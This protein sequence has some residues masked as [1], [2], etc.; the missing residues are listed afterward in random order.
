MAIKAEQFYQK[1]YKP[2][3]IKP[4]STENIKKIFAT[5]P[6]SKLCIYLR[7]NSQIMSTNCAI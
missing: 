2:K 7:A 6:I 3:N 5:N 4:K 1:T